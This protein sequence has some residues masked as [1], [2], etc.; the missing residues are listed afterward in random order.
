MK[1]RPQNKKALFSFTVIFL[2]L[3]NYAFAQSWNINGNAGI[4]SGT[5]YLG[6]KDPNDLVFRTNA[7]E[8]G[9]IFGGGGAW[10]FGSATNNMQVDSLGHLTFTGQGAYRVGGNKYAF[11]YSA[12]P[13]Y[14]LFFN[15]AS[16]QYEFRNGSAIPVFFIN[17]NTGAGTFASTLKVG[18]YTLPATD[19]AANQVLKTNGSG[20]LNWTNDNNTTYSAGTGISVIGTTINNTSPDQIVSL[21]G[22]NGISTSGSYPNFTINGS[23]LWKTTGNGGTSAST[24]FIGT[25]DAVDF[26]TRTNNTEIMRVT[27]GGNVGIGT[28]FPSYKLQVQAQD[29]GIFGSAS[30]I[31][32]AGN[33]G[34]YG[35]YGSSSTGYGV[36][37]LGS[38][39]GTIG[40]QGQADGIGVYGY[41][42][43]SSGGNGIY[44][45]AG[46]GT[47]VNCESTNGY[48]SYHYS[49][50]N[51]ALYA[52]DFNNTSYWA[53]FFV[54]DVYS[55]TGVYAS[56]DQN[57]KQNIKDFPSALKIIDQLKPKQYD[58]KHDGVY[59]KMNLPA[60]SHYGLIAQDVEK[61]LPNL[62]KY[63]KFEMPS[64]S[65]TGKG[66]DSTQQKEE[67]I[68]FKALNYTE[69][70]P[71]LIK[72]V[73]EQE[74]TIDNQQKQIDDLKTMVLNLAQGKSITST[75]TGSSIN[76]SNLT[77]SSAVLEQNVPN[78]LNNNTSIKYSIPPGSGN[79]QLVIT[80]ING[81][82]IKAVT[83]Q[84]GAGSINIDASTLSSGAY[85]Y[86][87]LINGKSITSRKMI[88]SR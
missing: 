19:G 44:G 86:T 9:R 13:N 14:G 83:L 34:S 2:F 37:G 72:A 5:N 63:S 41:C 69:F 21:S 55:S 45:Y 42:I 61:I 49:Y 87:L 40:V 75:N 1:S 32:V 66:P 35:V 33:G 81:K 20:A 4:V 73:Q 65:K 7:I 29:Y 67:A 3:C 51:N 43:S 58:Y 64:S 77:I 60:G 16:V 85:S 46:Y 11:Q 36:F 15:S 74:Q 56:S 38:G 71:I 78:P 18:A 50:N 27:S 57:L 52:Y 62:V 82:A 23:G 39:S 54:G 70:I 6:T 30:T 26:V 24:N 22:S 48:G 17:A 80:D 84:P 59:S 12:N 10:R 53:G 88:V 47:G 25:T 79:P 8:R 31:G 68:N 28:A 76:T